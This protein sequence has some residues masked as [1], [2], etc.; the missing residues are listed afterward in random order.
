M[1]Q[2][3]LRKI[4]QYVKSSCYTGETW[5]SSDGKISLGYLKTVKFFFEGDVCKCLHGK[6]MT[7][8][9][10]K[11]CSKYLTLEYLIIVKHQEES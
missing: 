11:L 4:I 10:L 2:T 5:M 9:F 8:D 3:F 1:S 6:I 7:H